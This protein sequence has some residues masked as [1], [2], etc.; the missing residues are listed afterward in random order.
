LEKILPELIKDKE[1]ILNS[2]VIESI[3]EEGSPHKT[4]QFKVVNY[5]LMIPVLSQAVKEQKEIIETQNK[6]LDRPEKEIEKIKTL[7]QK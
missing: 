2:N 6:K 7:L 3:S 1:L 4:E 5:T